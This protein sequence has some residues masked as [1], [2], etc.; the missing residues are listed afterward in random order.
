MNLKILLL[1]VIGLAFLA[2]QLA[3]IWVDYL[4]FDSLGYLSV[5][6]TVL[7]TR[8]A[9][10]VGS[11][12]FTTLFIWINLKA[13]GKN[14]DLEELRLKAR[15][16]GF[17]IFGITSVVA[18]LAA[19]FFC[20]TFYMTV[21][22]FFNGVPFGV[23]ETVFGNDLSFYFFRLP[24]W[25][26]T[27][28]YSLALLFVTVALVGAF[29][30]LT[31]QKKRE[32]EED[33]SDVMEGAKK[34]LYPL[35]GAFFLVL[36]VRV[37][38]ARY[39]LLYS[40]MGAVFGAAY[41]DVNFLLPVISVAS[42]LCA[43][44]GVLSFVNLKL[45][46]IKYPFYAFLALVLLLVFGGVGSALVQ[47]YHVDPAE[48]TVEEKYIKRNINHTRSAY[49]IK[50]MKGIDFTPTYNLAAEDL[51]EREKTMDNLRLWDYRVLED[52]Y[53]STQELRTYYE[54]KDVDVDRYHFDDGR[55]QVM[56]SVRELDADKLS[57]RAQTWVNRHLVYTHGSG[58]VMSPVRDV[59]LDGQP[60]FY[61]EDIPT[62]VTEEAP[63]Q[64]LLRLENPDVYFGEA[65]DNF[66]VVDTEQEELDYPAGGENVY[67]TYDGEGGIELNWFDRL[68]LAINLGDVRLLLSSDISTG[69]RALIRRNIHRRVRELAPFLRYDQDP[70]PVVHDGNIKWI[71]DTY[72]TSDKYP[73]S[74]PYQDINYIRNS[75]K[76]TVDA[77]DGSVD[78]YV[79]EDEPLVE[80]YRKIFPELF[81]E[82]EEMDGEM[83]KHIRYPEGLFGVQAEILTTYHMT[84]PRVFYNREDQWEIPE[85]TYRGRKQKVEP[86]YVTLELPE[87]NETQF[88]LMQPFTP[89]DRPN[90]VA[91]LGAKS[92]E[93]SY[94]ETLLY[95]FTKEELIYGPSQIESRIDQDAEISERLTLWDQRG[96]EVIRGNLLIIPIKDSVLYVEPVFLRGREEAIPEMRRVI[97]AYEDDISMQPTLEQALVDIFGEYEGIDEVPEELPEPGEG[98]EEPPVD[99][100]LLEKAKEHYEKAQ[101]YLQEGRL[102]DYQEEIER[103]GDVLEEMEL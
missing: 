43:A 59:T 100:E 102:G 71:Q 12:I 61:L 62:K 101:D 41:T 34:H 5:F 24:F 79:M 11:F 10:A 19:A 93:P 42:V 58:T 81:K 68:A 84:D 48:F 72:T 89:K 76:A 46:E 6:T 63:S 66:I 4:W 52:T 96:S 17:E 73:Y 86:Y 51:E 44:I 98:G 33:F 29:Y 85:E 99:A 3:E 20:S 9:L 94:G 55:K 49:G 15:L 1:A 26:L 32:A 64:E 16:K 67:T 23:E 36:A 56:L 90:M 21:L 18:G 14:I 78:F 13:A 2:P 8:V 92:D 22:K 75:V 97:V 87:E 47:S 60:Q 35:T 45:D 91:W 40:D 77:Y 95:H 31:V 37:F 74:E 65:A 30:Y 82:K 7:S 54:F 25:N 103:L 53:S 88:T 80:T 27:V 39:A 57:E 38:L 50:D 69:S 83:K 28:S 70:Y